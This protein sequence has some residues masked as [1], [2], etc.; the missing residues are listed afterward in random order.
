MIFYIPIDDGSDCC[1]K[2]GKFID[3]NPIYKYFFQCFFFEFYH[4]HY[5]KAFAVNFPT[6]HSKSAA[7]Q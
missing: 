1:D 5:I 3:A 6:F 7:I 2:E 4:Y